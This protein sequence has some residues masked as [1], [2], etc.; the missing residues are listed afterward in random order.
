MSLVS[1]LHVKKVD[2]NSTQ[3]KCYD[4]CFT[5]LGMLVSGDHVVNLKQRILML[6]FVFEVMMGCKHS[7]FLLNLKLPL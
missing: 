6:G 5:N 4:Y 1:Q 3:P 7:F 2:P